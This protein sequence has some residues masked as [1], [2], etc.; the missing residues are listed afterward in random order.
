MPEDLLKDKGSTP[1]VFFDKLYQIFKE[2]ERKTEYIQEQNFCIDDLHI[3][4]LFANEELNNRLA[5]ALD[6]LKEDATNHP[7]L[8]IC[9]WD[10]VST[11]I[12]IPPPPWT[13][14]HLYNPNQNTRFMYTPRGDIRG[15]KCDD[16]YTAFHM[17]A[18]V[19]TML[20]TKRKLAIYWT[21]DAR[22]LPVY[23]SRSPLRTVLHWWL[24]QFGLQL[25]HAG[26]VGTR[27]AGVLIAGK[28]G[29]GKS[30]TALT[31]LN[32]GLFYVSDD[33]CLIKNEP[34]PQVYTLYNAAK[35]N[36]ENI[37]RVRHLNPAFCNADPNEVEKVTF[38][39]NREFPEKIVRRLPV[40]AILLPR[41]T[42]GVDT[43]LTNASISESLSSIGLSSI[44]QLPDAGPITLKTLKQFVSNV[45]SYHLNLGTELSQI[46][47]IIKNLLI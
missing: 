34:E 12:K 37:E 41:V 46:S 1:A 44:A 42:G 15:Y 30:T 20:D 22:H 23:E 27:D 28:S 36:F 38:F 47:K 7:D 8:R 45:P 21:R 26:A 32:S 39:I 4:V 29:S 16:V 25:I 24:R 17:G 35:V 43:T 40:R 18:D 13:G 11:G 6:H 31:C 3:Q 2:V 19:L 10:E 33:Y 14:Y 5:P 9:V